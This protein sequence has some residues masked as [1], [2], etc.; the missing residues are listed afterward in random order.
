MQTI[1][2]TGRPRAHPLQKLVAAVR[3]LA[4]GES[5][6]RSDEYWRNSRS[7]VDNAVLDLVYYMVD[8]FGPN[9]FRQQNAE[10]LTIF[11]KRSAERG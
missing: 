3:V 1:D 6:D 11:L 2:A 10:K 5:T 9:Y 7:T 4:Y 8:I